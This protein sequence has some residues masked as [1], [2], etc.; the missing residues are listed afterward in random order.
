MESLSLSAPRRCARAPATGPDSRRCPRWSNRG[1]PGRGRRRLARPSR[2]WRRCPSI[3]GRRSWPAV[4]ACWAVWQEYT[5][6]LALR[7]AALSWSYVAN[8]LAVV[9]LGPWPSV[10][11]A[12]AAAW[13]ASVYRS[14][15]ARSWYRTVFTLGSTALSVPRPAWFTG[16]A[17]ALLPHGHWANL[18]LAMFAATVYFGVTTGPG[19]PGHG[20]VNRRHDADRYRRAAALQRSGLLCRRAARGADRR[21]V[22]RAARTGG[23]WPSPMPAYLAYRS[24]SAHAD[25][26][27]DD[28]AHVA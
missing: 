15:D 9:L 18:V 20:G 4:S 1:R 2:A 13:G 6:C 19:R 26:L 14:R 3:A 21:T 11:I 24:F 17:S 22:Q 7:G 28:H 8:M 10:P 25:R 5:R 12:V 16:A 23:P 27:A